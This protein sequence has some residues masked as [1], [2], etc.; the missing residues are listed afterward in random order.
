MPMIGHDAKPTPPHRHVLQHL[1]HHS[2]ERDIIHISP[3]KQRHSP[4]PE[5]DSSA[6]FKYQI[7]DA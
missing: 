3:K 5:P 2:H 4:L 7:L 1:G 6:F